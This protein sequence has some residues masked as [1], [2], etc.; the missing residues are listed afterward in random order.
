[1]VSILS[2]DYLGNNR[3]NSAVPKD[4]AVSQSKK[5]SSGVIAAIAVVSALVVIALAALT[6]FIIRRRKKRPVSQNP[7]EH[8]NLTHVDVSD[9]SLD[10]QSVQSFPSPAPVYKRFHHELHQDE[11]APPV[12]RIELPTTANDAPS[13]HHSVHQLPDHDNRASRDYSAAEKAMRAARTPEIGGEPFS[14]Y[15]LAGSHPNSIMELDDEES[16]QGLSPGFSP[17][18]SVRTVNTTRGSPR[19]PSP[20]S[21]LSPWNTFYDE[22]SDTDSPSRSRQDG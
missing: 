8:I 18:G 1:M 9:K 17:F 7:T 13:I 16:R 10:V 5:L 19:I 11:F 4:K 21:P 6:F 15:E 22:Q 2:A 14:R 3:S 12:P 20:M